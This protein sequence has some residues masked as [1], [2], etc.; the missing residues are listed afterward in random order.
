[1]HI[2]TC[3]GEA[4]H[5]HWTHTSIDAT[6][7]EGRGRAYAL[8]ALSTRS[9]YPSRCGS[10]FLATFSLIYTRASGCARGTTI[11]E[12]CVIALGAEESGF[13]S[14]IFDVMRRA[15]HPSPSMGLRWGG[16]DFVQIFLLHCRRRKKKVLQSVSRI[17]A[18][19]VSNW[20]FMTPFFP[21]S[22]SFLALE[23]HSATSSII[24]SK[25]AATG[26]SS[27]S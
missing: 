4:E 18:G 25:Q 9:S 23:H 15:Q 19:A 14:A 8:F 13:T 27:Q 2:V 20:R 22:W 3:S 11:K 17:P 1:M 5:K 21:Q 12:I 6:R 10:E 16:S 7:D 24:Q 26:L